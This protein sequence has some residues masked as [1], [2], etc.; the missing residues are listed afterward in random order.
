VKLIGLLA[1]PAFIGVAF[2][3]AALFDIVTKR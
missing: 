1:I 3:I 2:G